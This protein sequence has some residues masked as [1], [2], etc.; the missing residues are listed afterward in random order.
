MFN[1]FCESNYFLVALSLYSPAD[2]G[3]EVRTVFLIVDVLVCVIGGPLVSIDLK[4]GVNRQVS[5]KD[6]AAQG[7]YVPLRGPVIDIIPS[8]KVP[9]GPSD[10][11]TTVL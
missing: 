10:C 9:R 4:V 5:L 8:G 1:Y 7:V 6:H 11:P 3:P 2:D